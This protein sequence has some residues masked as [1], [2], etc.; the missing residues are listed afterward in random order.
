MVNTINTVL[1]KSICPLEISSVFAQKF[2]FL[3][4]HKFP[5]DF[6]YQAKKE[7]WA[8][9]TTWESCKVKAT[10]DQKITKAPLKFDPQDIWK[11]KKY[12][13]ILKVWKLCISMNLV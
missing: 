5:R 1:R 4:L 10:D 6:L 3:S 13:K 12:D 8:N 9:M 11:Y 2:F 7:E